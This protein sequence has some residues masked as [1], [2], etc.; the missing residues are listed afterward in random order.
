MTEAF[1]GSRWWRFDFHTHTPAS[2]DYDS[3]EAATLTPREWLLAYMH[4]NVDA[5]AVTDHNCS[6]WIEQLQQAL[7]AL[8]AEQPAGW[9]PLVL[10][11]GVEV[12]A[13]DGLHVLAL[14]APAISKSQIDGLLYGKL[15]GWL[16]DKPSAERQCTQSAADVIDAVHSL[17][18]L[19]IPAHVDKVNGLLFGS[20]D[21]AGQFQP[22]VAGRSIDGGPAAGRRIGTARPQ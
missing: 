19:A 13:G 7:A 8:D 2:S 5:V 12:S 3:T 6:D 4:A 15:S 17:R 1:P 20:V 18:G 9:R 14:F 10:F 16:T 21:A 22:R 11:P